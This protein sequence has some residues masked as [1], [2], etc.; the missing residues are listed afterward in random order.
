MTRVSIRLAPSHWARLRLGAAVVLILILGAIAVRW[1]VQRQDNFLR[2][3]LRHKAHVVA[4]SIPL[5]RLAVLD[6]LHGEAPPPPEYTRLHSQLRR[7]LQMDPAWR[8][9]VLMS[10]DPSGVLYVQMSS[11]DDDDAPLPPLSAEPDPQRRA[12]LLHIFDTRKTEIVGPYQD[13]RGAWISAL[14]PVID[15][16][17]GRLVSVVGIDIAADAWRFKSWRAGLVPG[18]L[19][20]GLLGLVLLGTAL[21]HRKALIPERLQHH[22]HRLEAFLTLALGTLLTLAGMWLAYIHETRHRQEA[23]LAVAH[24]NA[25]FVAEAFHNLRRAE[26]ESLGR[27]FESSVDV[28][29]AEFRTYA[30]YLTRV[31][32][33]QAWGWIPRVPAQARDEF[34]TQ[35][36]HAQGP[37]FDLW[38]FDAE[39]RPTTVQDRPLHFP[40]LFLAPLDTQGARGLRPGFDLAS[41]DFFARSVAAATEEGLPFASDLQTVGAA[42]AATPLML[43]F[44]PVYSPVEPRQPQGF[45]MSA[46]LPHVFL[47]TVLN[48]H[49]D[50]NPLIQLELLELRESAAPVRLAATAAADLLPP[51]APLPQDPSQRW[52]LPILAFGR[53]YAVVASPARDFFLQHSIYVTWIAGVAGGAITLALAVLISVLVHRREDL[54][55]LVEQRTNA[56]ASSFQHYDQLAR[57]SRTLTWEVDARGLFTRISDVVQDVWGF[58]PDDLVGKQYFFDLHPEDGREAFTHRI[59]D[60]FRARRSFRNWINPVKSKSGHILWMSTSGIPLLDDQGTLTGYQGFETDVTETQTTQHALRESERQLRLLTENMKDVAW[61]ID[62]QSFQFLYVSPSVEK[63]LGVPRATALTQPLKAIFAPAQYTYFKRRIKA[64]ASEFRAGQLSDQEYFTDQIDLIRADG[65]VVPTETVSRF[66]GNDE[67]GRAELQGITRDITERKQA[68]NAL[69]ESRRQYAALVANLP[70]MAYRCTNDPAWTMEFVSDGCRELTGYAPEDLVG[71]RLL[72]YNDLIATPHRNRV[73]EKWQKLL[74]SHLPCEEEYEIITRSG[75][76]KWV[77]EKGEGVYDATGRVLA[78]EGFI[79]DITTRKLANLERERLMAAIEQS[80]DAIIITDPGGAISYVNPAFCTV[81]GYARQEA[82]GQNPRILQSG[83]QDHAFY[84]AMWQTLTAG[85]TWRGQL[86]NKRKDGTLFTEVASIS[87]VRDSDGCIVQYVAVKRD[88]TQQLLDQQERETLQAQLLQAQKMESIGRL[89]G[90]IAHDFNNMLQAILGYTELSLEQATPDQP[91]YADLMEIQKAAQRS[92][93][94]THQLQAFARKQPVRSETLD[95]NAAIDSMIGMFHPLLGKNIHL[96]WKPATDLGWVQV[97]PSHLDQLLTNLCLNARDAISDHGRITIETCNVHIARPIRNL[98]GKIPAGDYVRLSVTDTG[99]GMTPETLEH[100]FEPFYTTK[101]EGM[102]TGLGLATIYGIIRQNSAI[103]RILSQPGK[104]TVF[105]VFFP[106]QPQQAPVADAP[107]RDGAASPV[108]PQGTETILIAEDEAALLQTTG[109]MLTSLGYT[110]QAY[111]SA[112]QALEF[113]KAHPDAFD[114]LL[115]DVMMPDLAGPKLVQRLQAVRPNLR[116]LYMSGYT[117]N[118]FGEKSGTDTHVQF[119]RKPFSRAQLA[120]KIRDVLDG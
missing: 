27:F 49:L 77:W 98:Y 99:S 38:E 8:R 87:P 113:A 100:I 43:V 7:I 70:G 95:L 115:T 76:T 58:A 86:I 24:L 90:G 96:D 11:Q 54:E 18:L 111:P 108:V 73:W 45:V 102:G 82:L 56:L 62:A 83:A 84:N 46:L 39:G 92:K 48:T 79:I 35:A 69:R 85:R 3:E 26:L 23:F 91:L 29:D 44:R 114:L 61:S 37:D 103:P 119:I 42:N 74:A 68:E 120:R 112:T 15:A 60:E 28:T 105:Q 80:D 32:I 59:R 64:N 36:R 33:G 34:V 97:D 55:R 13:A 6:R 5:D 16:T 40:L 31:S 93:A 94:L 109:R 67:T 12:Q 116:Y 71:N 81:T 106:R 19:T 89:A 22:W 47:Q 51:D 9:M 21:R 25:N 20:L 17:T 104:G 110:V 107:A 117:A 63:L 14:T 66:V 101:K 78:L 4:R 118:L 53:T 50:Q 10:R 57:Y 75:E 1:A 72:A 88:I 41:L 65:T 2:E 52:T 30:D